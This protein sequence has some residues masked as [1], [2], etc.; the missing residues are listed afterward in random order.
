MIAKHY[1]HFYSDN[2]IDQYDQKLIVLFFR[3]I[4]QE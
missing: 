3:Y 1:L 2:I 4:T